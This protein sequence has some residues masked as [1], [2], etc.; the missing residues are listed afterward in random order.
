[1]T[2]SGNGTAK[3]YDS[4]TDTRSVADFQFDTGSK[5]L[6]MNIYFLG[7][8]GTKIITINPT[9]PAPIPPQAISTLIF[10]QYD[11]KNAT[12]SLTDAP[13]YRLYLNFDNDWKI[14]EGQKEYKE[15]TYSI[16]G[17]TFYLKFKIDA[18]SVEYPPFTD[19]EH[20]K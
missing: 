14:L 12:G 15:T 7:A 2:W 6:K 19:E 3:L 4:S 16:G 9:P 13:Y 1:M 11:E 10:K 20:G 8:M 18:M 17:Q 5:L